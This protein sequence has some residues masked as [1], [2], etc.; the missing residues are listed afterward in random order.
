[1]WFSPVREKET[2]KLLRKVVNITDVV[3]ACKDTGYEWFEQFLRS[4]LKKEECEKVKPVEKACKQIVECLVQNIMRLEEISGQNNQRLVACLATL[5]LLTKIR[6]EL[7]VQYTM[8]LQTYLR[9]NENSDPHV[10]HYVARILEVTVP[11]MEHPSESFVAQ[12]EEDMVKLTL[13]HGKMVLESC[14]A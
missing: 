4:L 2:V 6:P 14:V 10:L 1:M 8:V 3:A 13:K 9:C 7:M 12:L 5:H 11:L